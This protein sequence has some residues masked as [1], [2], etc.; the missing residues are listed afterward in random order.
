M[1]SC[2]DGLTVWC[3]SLTLGLWGHDVV[4]ICCEAALAGAEEVT[5][6]Y[7]W[8]KL[9]VCC[10]SRLCLEPQQGP[11]RVFLHQAGTSLQGKYN[12]ELTEAVLENLLLDCLREC[13]CLSLSAFPQKVGLELKIHQQEWL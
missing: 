8:P 11:R 12:D 5:G 2:W 13:G 10:R 3:E 9:C 7:W 4:T 6:C 1:P